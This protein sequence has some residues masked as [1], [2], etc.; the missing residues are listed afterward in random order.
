LRLFQLLLLLVLIII[1]L[2]VILSI[3]LVCS[4]IFWHSVNVFCFLVVEVVI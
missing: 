1:L 3:H 2:P 4:L